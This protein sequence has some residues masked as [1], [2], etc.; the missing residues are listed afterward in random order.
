MTAP[1]GDLYSEYYDLIY[2]DKD[3]EKECD[4]IESLFARYSGRKTKTILEL[5]AGTGAYTIPMGERGYKVLATDISAPML[6]LARAKARKKRLTGLL[7][8]EVSDM[9]QV[10]SR[11]TFDA[12]MCMFAA[13]DYLPSLSDVEMTFKSAW[14]R[15]RPKGLFVFDF[16]NGEA[17]LKVGPSQR[18]KVVRERNTTLIRLATPSLDLR[19]KSCG[20]HYTT[21][22][23]EG[24]ELKHEFSEHHK[25]RYLFLDEV[26]R[27]LANSGFDLLSLHPFLSPG[28]KVSAR[29]WNVT[30]VASRQ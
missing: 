3:Y 28:K 17:V 10:R 29:D 22:V 6:E 30:A 5:G 20:I 14:R 11:E 2:H 12:C 26:R 15:L 16:W 25:V 1:F 19:A 7:S 27:V 18:F 8:F 21:F 24:H 23:I 4:Y 13:I 9:R